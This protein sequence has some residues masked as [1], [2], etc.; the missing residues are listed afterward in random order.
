LR[1]DYRDLAHDYDR[2]NRLR[3]DIA[4]DQWRLNEA[5]RCGRNWQAAQIAR[6]IDRDRRVLEYQRR[7]IR[8]DEHDVYRDRRDLHHD[9]H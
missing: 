2:V 7:D 1:S 9:Y 6:D 3:S 8:R 4:R 5:L